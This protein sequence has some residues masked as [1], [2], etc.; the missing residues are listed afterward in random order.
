MAVL[1]MLLSCEKDSYDKGTGPYSMLYADFANLHVDSEK[2]ALYF[3]TDETDSFDVSNPFTATWITTPDST[4][5]TYLYYYREGNCQAQVKAINIMPTLIPRDA[6]EYKSLPQDPL[7]LESA[8]L[9]T[10]GKYINMGLLLKNGRDE[11]GKEGT[12]SLALALDEVRKN[13]DQT[14]TACYRLLHDQGEAPEYYTNRR[15]VC[16]QLPTAK[17]ERPDSVCLTVN[18]YDG[19]V[20]VKFKL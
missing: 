9:T 10:D 15:Y 5:R 16:I 4:Y 6:K 11:N 19:V 14:A 12:Q 17:E 8:W 18:T 1:C 13:D 20:V 2:Q 7:G 3:I